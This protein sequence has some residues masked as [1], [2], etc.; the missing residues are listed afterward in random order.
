M[1][2]RQRRAI[3]SAYIHQFS[4]RYSAAILNAFNHA[5]RNTWY[6]G[7]DGDVASICFSDGR[8]ANPLSYDAE[9]ASLIAR[10][11]CHQERQ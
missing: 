10:G 3:H 9:D 8:Q 11:Y 2:T 7:Y 4:P 1:T 6:P 5:D